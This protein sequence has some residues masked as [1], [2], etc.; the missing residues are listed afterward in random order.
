MY[1]RCEV[2]DGWDVGS[3]A[4]PA[5]NVAYITDTPGGAEANSQ[6]ECLPPDGWGLLGLVLG[7]VG[8]GEQ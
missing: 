8:G 7:C 3:R 2:P 5:H 1:F 6:V 4:E